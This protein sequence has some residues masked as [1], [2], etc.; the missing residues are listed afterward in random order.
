MLPCLSDVSDSP[1]LEPGRAG[2]ILG[3]ACLQEHLCMRLVEFTGS[4]GIVFACCVS[5]V[6]PVC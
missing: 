5:W 4:D 1:D 3:Q 2:D 6:R